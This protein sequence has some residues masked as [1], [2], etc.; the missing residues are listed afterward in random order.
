MKKTL[1]TL[2]IF[3]S[4]FS[5]AQNPL[6]KQWDARFG[7]KQNDIVSAFQETADGGFIIGGSS[8]SVVSGNKTQPTQGGF[9]YWI[10]KTDAAGTLQWEKDYGGSLPEDFRDLQQTRDHG[11]ILA[12][13]TDSPVSGDKT[14]PVWGSTDF[15][16]VRLDSLG[17]KIWDRDFGGT[18][19]DNLYSVQQTSD[20]G[21]ILGGSSQSQAGGDKTQ[22]TWTASEDY[23]IVKIDSLGNKQ[24]DSDLGGTSTDE[25]GTVTQTADGG[26][27]LCGRSFSG[28]GGD[29]SQ[30]GFGGVDCWIVKTDALGNKIWD[31]SYGGT[32][33]DFLH[34]ARQTSDHGFIIGGF[35]YSGVGGNKTTPLWGTSG[36]DYWV[37][38]TDSLGVKQWEKDFG[39]TD[40]EDDFGSVF[41]TFDHGFLFAGTS[42]SPISGDK[43]ESNLGGE[44]SWIV[45]TD[46][47]GAM[48][49]E[50]T[51]F[52][53]GHDETGFAIQ[54]RDGCYAFMNADNGNTGGYR[55]QPNWDTLISV[56]TSADYWIVKFCDTTLSMIPAAA[57]TSPNHICPGTCTDFTNLSSNAISYQWFFPGANPATSVDVNPHN[58]CYNAPGTYDVT[59]I[60]ENATASD[61]LTLNN[62]I[63][64][65]PYPPPQGITQSGDTLFAIGGSA[66]YQWYFNGNLISGATNY[67]YVAQTSGD[68]NVV[69]T[70][71]NGCEVEAAIFNVLAD[72]QF[73]VSGLKFEVYPNP[74]TDKFTIHEAQ[75][76]IRAADEISVDNALGENV[77]VVCCGLSTVDCGL[78]APGIYFL[79]LKSGDKIMRSRFIKQ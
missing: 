53:L 27:L 35:T 78:L 62:Y 66:S 13:Y 26:Y 71:I 45:K 67:F 40:N 23:W 17:N 72:V 50:K 3:F 20:G 18:S 29:K 41:E 15:W 57:F 69:A 30:A 56:S 46:S 60:A 74:V 77:L 33:D 63:T 55:T 65:Y 11:Y 32:A 68:Y 36:T 48:E 47:L 5:S 7:G 76:T 25:L 1:L 4:L 2:F 19:V 52:T 8:M 44:Q 14:Q 51:L 73:E 28:V 24:W 79:E 75:F 61:T 31:M 49:W 64:V 59:L 42:Y 38:K 37:I 54:T 58:I 6:V 43:S 16:I 22:N 12:G 10:V 34:S 39:G 70:D 9:D 21:F